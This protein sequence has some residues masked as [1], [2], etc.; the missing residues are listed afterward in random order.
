MIIYLNFDFIFLYDQSSGHTKIRE[1]SLIPSNINVVYSGAVSTM[2]NTTI[3]EIS[4]HT[5]T[6]HVG[7]EQ[8]MN[9]EETGEGPFWLEEEI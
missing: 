1:D 3:H 4:P 8:Q 7:Y 5:P 9:F 6:F 2:Y